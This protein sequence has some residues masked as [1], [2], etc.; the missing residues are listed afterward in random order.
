VEISS[1]QGPLIA[2]GG[3]D[4][5][6]S[7]RVRKTHSSHFCLAR[8]DENRFSNGKLR[9]EAKLSKAFAANINV[10]LHCAALLKITL[11]LSTAI[12]IHMLKA[13]CTRPVSVSTH[14]VE[15]L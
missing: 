10:S 13:G 8:S 7:C 14:L 12:N 15:G 9:T 3:P 11:Q 2:V 6:T 4:G 1:A 5:H